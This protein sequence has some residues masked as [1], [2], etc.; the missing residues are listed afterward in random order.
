MI[1]LQKLSEFPQNIRAKGLPLWNPSG[2]A[3]RKA[4]KK[5]PV[6]LRR[7]KEQMARPKKPDSEKLTRTVAWRVTEAVKAEMDQQ[8]AKSGL[9]QSEFLR[10]LLQCKKATIVAKPRPSADLKQLVFLFN[11]ASNNINQLA[12]RANAAHLDGTENEQTYAGIL[13]ALQLLNEQ[14]KRGIDNAN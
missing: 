6:Q 8:Y 7:E 2:Y 1:C 3:A 5:K 12:H 9:T 11:K 13:A 10:E 14:L 4:G